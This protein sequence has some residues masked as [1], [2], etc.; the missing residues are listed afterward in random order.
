MSTDH[1]GFS[2]ISNLD[3]HHMGMKCHMCGGQESL[4]MDDDTSDMNAFLGGFT[5]RH[6]TCG[7]RYPIAPAATPKKTAKRGKV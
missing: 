5:D 7:T 6:A 4:S 2:C 3:T 1:A